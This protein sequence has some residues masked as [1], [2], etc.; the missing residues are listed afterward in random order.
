MRAGEGAGV[1]AAPDA[2]DAGEDG[3]AIDMLSGDEQRALRAALLE[4]PEDLRAATRQRIEQLIANAFEGQNAEGTDEAAARR[5]DE[6]IRGALAEAG[7]AFSLGDGAPLEAETAR[8]VR[9]LAAAELKRFADG[10]D[11]S[12]SLGD[13]NTPDVATALPYL[14]HA[15]ED[16]ALRAGLGRRARV[17][18]VRRQLID[19]DLAAE[20]PTGARG[21]VSAL[22][23]DEWGREPLQFVRYADEPVNEAAEAWLQRL[24]ERAEAIAAQLDAWEGPRLDAR[25]RQAAE[26]GDGARLSNR[27]G[28]VVLSRPG[29]VEQAIDDHYTAVERRHLLDAYGIAPLSAEREQALSASPDVAFRVGP[30]DPAQQG[31]LAPAAVVPPLQAMPQAMPSMEPASS[32]AAPG[33]WAALAAVGR[34]AA[35]RAALVGGGA[36]AAVAAVEAG[37]VAAGRGLERE[38]ATSAIEGL[39][40]AAASDLDVVAASLGRQAEILEALRRYAP[41]A[42]DQALTTAAQTLREQAGGMRLEA[43]LLQSD[44]TVYSGAGVTDVD[45]A[46]LVAERLETAFGASARV[47]EG[48]D[49]AQAFGPLAETAETTRAAQLQ[50]EALWGEVELMRGHELAVSRALDAI[51]AGR[52]ATAP[53]D[54]IDQLLQGADVGVRAIGDHAGVA[55]Q[56]ARQV[57]DGVVERAAA[58][59]WRAVATDGAEAL[60]QVGESTAAEWGPRVSEA[61]SWLQ[62]TVSAAFKVDDDEPTP[63]PSRDPLAAG[64]LYHWQRQEVDAAR[65]AAEAEGRQLDARDEVTVRI[66]ARRSWRMAAVE[67]GTPVER[68]DI[69]LP[70]EGHVLEVLRSRR[71][72]RDLDSVPGSSSFKLADAATDVWQE[73]EGAWRRPDLPLEVVPEGEGFRLAP[74]AGMAAAL[75]RL[76][77]EVAETA[78]WLVAANSRDLASAALPAAQAR[79]VTASLDLSNLGAIE[80]PL[81][82]AQVSWLVGVHERVGAPLPDLASREPRREAFRTAEAET[83]T[84]QLQRAEAT[85]APLAGEALAAARE[86][87]PQVMSAAVRVERGTVDGRAVDRYTEGEAVALRVA[88][89]GPAV[90]VREGGD[91]RLA[92]GDALRRAIARSEIAG[93]EDREAAA[94]AA[95]AALPASRGE[96]A[97]EAAAPRAPDDRGTAAVAAAVS[98]RLRQEADVAARSAPP[99][100]TAGG[101]AALVEQATAVVQSGAAS[102]VEAARRPVAL[103]ADADRESVRA[104]LRAMPQE[105]LRAVAAVTALALSRAPQGATVTAVRTRTALQT[106]LD[107]VTEV[108]ASRGVPLPRI[109]GPQTATRPTGRGVER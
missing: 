65:T 33:R 72:R 30:L 9:G 48:S 13:G 11:A 89:G 57:L 62:A 37:Q 64:T 31:G 8:V 54:T 71:D 95:A 61:F 25:A 14:D 35:E 84:R 102:V 3:M 18:S 50:I 49:L 16:A 82:A 108:A 41:A 66:A 27:S 42:D 85:F 67:R 88:D 44:P 45:A 29:K 92:P 105:D 24:G 53:A 99:P 83:L 104:A 5:L 109:E 23:L 59:D 63:E 81:T 22:D 47:I 60:R 87:R 55:L 98:D 51:E 107:L 17:A 69:G 86:Q 103:A 40:S 2:A 6:D 90:L 15:L 75:D 43:S 106:G 80:P 94:Q 38:L 28:R 46:A 7:V 56:Q 68:A 19:A 73:S 20:H 21:H 32:P 96:P 79:A 36:A 93:R 76:D 70:P 34:A 78:R 91:P 39:R 10:A 101:L 58:T 12:F 100:P 77:P 4:V 74:T 97:V 1:G 52:A 26:A